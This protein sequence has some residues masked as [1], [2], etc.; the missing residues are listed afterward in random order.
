MDFQSIIAYLLV[1]AAIF[2]LAKKFFF[3]SKSKGKCG[4]DDCKCG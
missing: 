3:K 1:A 4:T 2:F